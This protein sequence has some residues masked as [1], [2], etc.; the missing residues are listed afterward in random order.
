MWV[1]E[2]KLSPLFSVSPIFFFQPN[3]GKQLFPPYFPFSLFSSQPNT[4]LETSRKGE[5]WD[6]MRQ[7][8]CL[9]LSSLVQQM[10]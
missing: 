1:Q 2:G 10:G 4:P 3:S 5:S 6:L 8:P 7:L 9:F